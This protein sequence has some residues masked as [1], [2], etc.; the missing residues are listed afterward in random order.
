MRE[1]PEDRNENRGKP[2]SFSRTLRRMWRHHRREMIGFGL[3]FLAVIIALTAILV[4]GGRKPQEDEKP[5]ESSNMVASSAD[6]YGDLFADPSKGRKKAG[7]EGSLSGDAA[8]NGGAEENPTVLAEVAGARS[9]YLNNCVFLGDSRTVGAV[10]YGF[11]SDKDALAEIGIAHT[12]AENFTYTQNSGKQYTMR[13]FLAEKAAPVVYVCYG[14]NGMNGMDEATYE[15]TYKTLVEHI[16]DMAPTS[17]IVLMSIWPVNDNGM[18]KGAVKNEWIDKYNEFLKTLAEYEGIYYL[19]VSSV[20][21]NS[22]GGIKAEFDAGDG[23][24]YQAYAYNTIIDY[25]ISH[26]VPG[27]SDAGEYVVHYVAPRPNVTSKLPTP[28]PFTPTPVPEEEEEEPTPEATA[29]P[30]LTPTPEETVSQNVPTPTKKPTPIPTPEVSPTPTPE[31]SPTEGPTEGVTPTPTPTKGDEPS[32]SEGATPTPTK[33][34]DPGESPTP[35]PSEGPSEGPSPG[36]RIPTP[37][38]GGGYEE[39]RRGHGNRSLR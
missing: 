33:G 17:N 37:S 9:G 2:R 3:L 11:I 28:V 12:S 24:H 6:P 21:K 13:S 31:P 26:P 23:L 29:T 18:Y 7:N 34:E 38:G 10:I 30:T 15:R 27:V 8:E 35:V 20:L 19:D 1:G 22:E 16:I 25:I 14:V 5:A 4:F 39:T 36:D 32:P